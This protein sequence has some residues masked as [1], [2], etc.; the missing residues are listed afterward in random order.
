MD[1]INLSYSAAS[2]SYTITVP[3]YQPGQLVNSRGGSGSYSNGHWLTLHSSVS[4]VSG[5]TPGSVQPVKVVLDW[6]AD[7][8]FSYTS[9]GDWLGPVAAAGGRGD[10]GIFAYGIPTAIGDVPAV[11]TATY[12]GTVHGFTTAGYGE[13]VWGSVHMDVDFASGA[14]TGALNL[15]YSD[16]W[17]PHEL[18]PLTFRDTVYASGGTIF[19]GSFA[20]GGIPLDGAFSGR[21]TGPGAAEA[22]ASFMT[23]FHYTG[24]NQTGTIAGAWI[25]KK[26]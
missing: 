15:S 10:N 13:D 12:N 8:S 5:S 7:S 16:G 26:P 22:M 24:S 23:E 3:G 6:P 18:A 4:D 11:G 19:S 9:F 14:L 20:Q 2:D 21:F 1:Q 25:A 17:D